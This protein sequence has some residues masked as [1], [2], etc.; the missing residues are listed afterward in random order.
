MPTVE[1]HIDRYVEVNVSLEDF[2]TLDLL[3]EIGKRDIGKQDHLDDCASP[4]PCIVPPLNSEEVHPLHR[5][6]YRLKLGDDA[7][8]IEEMRKYLSDELGVVL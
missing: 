3:E 1:V 6:Y 8:A 5:V 7:G 4:I 2:D